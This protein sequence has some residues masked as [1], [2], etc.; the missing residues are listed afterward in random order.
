MSAVRGLVCDGGCGRSITWSQSRG[1]RFLLKTE[2]EKEARHQGWQ[3]PDKLG[4][5]FCWFCRSEDGRNQWRRRANL[6]AGLPADYGLG[7]CPGT[8]GCNCSR[9]GHPGVIALYP[10]HP[11]LKGTDYA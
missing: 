3:A 5:H 9:D 7:R 11:R 2:Q 8:P 4:R 6:A 1:G 10:G